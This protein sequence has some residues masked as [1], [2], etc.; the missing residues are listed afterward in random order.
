VTVTRDMD[1][2]RDQLLPLTGVTVLDFSMVWAGPFATKL[3][4]DMGATVIKVESPARI[5]PI[6][7]STIEIF[8]LELPDASSQ[9]YNRSAYFNEYNRNKLSLSIDTVDPRGRAVMERLISVSDVLVE[10]FRP[11]VLGR[12]GYGDEVL[13]RLRPGIV[14]VSMPAYSSTGSESRMVGYG[15]NIEEMSGLTRLNGYPDGPPLKTGISFGDPMAGTM[16]AAGSLL[17]LI[18]RHRTG[19]GSRIEVAQRDNL[20]GFLGEAIMEWSMNGRP[21]ARTG[22]RSAQWAPQGCYLCLPL[23]AES[24]R[25]LDVYHSA[26]Q[27][28]A[29]CERWVTISVRSDAEWRDLCEVMDRADL[30]ADPRYSTVGLRLA[31][32]DEIDEQIAAW[33]AGRSDADAAAALQARGVPAVPVMSCLDLTKD[34]HLAERG[35]LQPAVHPVAGRTWLTAPAWRLHG[36][37]VPIRRPAPCLGQDNSAV[38]RQIAGLSDTKIAELAAAGVTATEPRPRR[39]AVAGAGHSGAMPGPDGWSRR[40]TG[41]GARGLDVPRPDATFAA[42]PLNGIRVLEIGGGVAVPAA[43]RLLAGFGADVI[44]VETPEGD[45]TRQYGPFPAD[46]ANPE[47]S[48]LFLCLNTGKR[49]VSLDYFSPEGRATLAQLTGRCNLLLTSLAPRQLDNLGLHYE[50]LAAQDQALAMV[51]VTSFGLSGPYRDFEATA[52]TS[53]ASGGQMW[54]TGE[55][56]QPPV[57]NFGFQAEHQAGCHAFAAG[58]TLL[59]HALTTGR[60]ELIEISIQ[61]A[62]ASLLE[63][64]GPNAFNH[65]TESFRHGNILRSTWGVFPCADGYVGIHAL[66]RN[67]PNLFRAMDRDDLTEV[68]MDPVKRSEDNDLLTAI[69]YGW[70]SERTQAEIFAAGVAAG[71]P[72]GYLPRLDELLAWP[73][74]AQKG[75][76]RYVDHPDAGLRPYPAAPITIEG[77]PFT[78][79]RAPRLGEH[80]AEVLTEAGPP[81]GEATDVAGTASGA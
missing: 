56:Y 53:F 68:Y 7:M 79:T 69:L 17:G 76:W 11:G 18:R 37:P 26:G 61:E 58:L 52:L 47:A 6:R 2:Q 35:F 22:N 81:P 15:P 40:V 33:T 63:V 67:L 20:L 32:Q 10:N 70:C 74:L 5:D 51:S 9:P 39:P 55:P 49:S 46:V 19:A 45:A 28:A 71:A 54:M 44:K 43:G 31:A 8:M 42:G 4:A 29:V 25:K 65:G 62:Q 16:A 59:Y 77:A 36:R 13:E 78:V 57:K 60:G 27:G 24:E 64:N 1:G 66:E 14:R 80:T 23:T 30:A 48:G 73:G 34:A 75:F 21:P 72:I 12:L 3:L 41:P 38:L 50:Q